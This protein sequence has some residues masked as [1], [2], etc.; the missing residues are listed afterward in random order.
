MKVDLKQGSEKL[1]S[2]GQAVEATFAGGTFFRLIHLC[3][4]FL[5]RFSDVAYFFTENIKNMFFDKFLLMFEVRNFF[6]Y[7]YYFS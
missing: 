2:S 5:F 6:F 4:R 1:A 7:D 3:S